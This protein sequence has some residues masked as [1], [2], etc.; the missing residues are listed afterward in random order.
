MSVL[1]YKPTAKKADGTVKPVKRAAAKTAPK[2]QMP[3]ARKEFDLRT[4]HR[5][6]KERNGLDVDEFW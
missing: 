3:S 6:W 1:K 5:E 2:R 4:A